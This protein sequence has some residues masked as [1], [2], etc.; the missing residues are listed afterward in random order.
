MVR[1]FKTRIIRRILPGALL[2]LVGLVL[3]VAVVLLLP[4]S[5]GALLGWSI[6]YADDAL[7]GH[8]TAGEVGWPSLDRVVLK[9]VL[10]ISGTAAAPGDTL[11]DLANLDLTVDLGALR[12]KDARVESL[13]VEARHLNVPGMAAVFEDT[14]ANASP[15]STAPV[16]E[17]A[18]LVETIKTTRRVTL[19]S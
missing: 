8:L 6:R 16:T 12:K 17:P 5:R 7:P 9:D 1:L 18:K 13:L 19:K 14:E 15:D 10:W 3:I 11:A 2:L 4:A